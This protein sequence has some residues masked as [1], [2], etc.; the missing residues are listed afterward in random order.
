MTRD[1]FPSAMQ[2]LLAATKVAE[3]GS[4]FGAC[5][6]TNSEEANRLG[7]EIGTVAVEQTGS[8]M[9]KVGYTWDDVR[10]AF[11]KG[12]VTLLRKYCPELLT[13]N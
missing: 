1:E 6:A 2:V 3:V 4:I 13:P 11:G 7:E 10:V 12:L 8:V 9:E 5:V